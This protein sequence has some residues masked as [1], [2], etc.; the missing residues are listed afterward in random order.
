[1]VSIA[2]NPYDKAV[3]TSFSTVFRTRCYGCIALLVLLECHRHVSKQARAANI[4]SVTDFRYISS[5]SVTS[6]PD[7]QIF[8]V[9]WN[10]W[11]N[12]TKGYKL[13]GSQKWVVSAYAPADTI[14]STHF[15]DT[16]TEARMRGRSGLMRYFN[17]RTATQQNPS[18]ATISGNS[19]EDDLDKSCRDATRHF[20][21]ISSR[22]STAITADTIWLHRKL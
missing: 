17:H 4:L 3:E 13:L 10:S 22:W 18:D 20:L 21:D 9:R 1:M 11:N 12:F 16:G 15:F 19:G 14:V 5:A 6:V 2:A 8:P 7:Y